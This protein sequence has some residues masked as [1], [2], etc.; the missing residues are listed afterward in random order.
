MPIYFITAIIN[1]FGPFNFKP[2][3]TQGVYK[4]A[5]FFVSSSFAFDKSNE[6]LKIRVY[7]CVCK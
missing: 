5:H 3:F 2:M 1:V 7:V 6:G 4:Y